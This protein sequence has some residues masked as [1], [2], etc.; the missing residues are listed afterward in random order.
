MLFVACFEQA[1]GGGGHECH[2][3]FVLSREWWWWA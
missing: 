1:S 3:S 2:L